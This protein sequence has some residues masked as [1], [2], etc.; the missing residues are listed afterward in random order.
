MSH[1]PDSSDVAEAPTEVERFGL[2]RLSQVAAPEQRS[3]LT[4]IAL[5]ECVSDAM[6]VT[7]L[8]GEIVAANQ[9]TVQLFGYDHSQLNSARMSIFMASESQQLH[10]PQLQR[11]IARMVR[12]K[13][14]DGFWPPDFIHFRE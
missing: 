2:R 1:S 13:Q 3:A 4:V 10:M 8:A 7:N 14:K 12:C 11:F 5:T 6:V 9:A